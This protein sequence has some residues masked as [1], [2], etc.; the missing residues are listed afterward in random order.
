LLIGEFISSVPF[1]L[2]HFAYLF[3]LGHGGNSAPLE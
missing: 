2:F 1:F 3:L